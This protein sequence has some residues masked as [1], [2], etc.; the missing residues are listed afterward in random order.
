[1]KRL[2]ELA[3][4][5]APMLAAAAVLT[6]LIQAPLYLFPVLEGSAYQGINIQQYGSDE[7]YYLLR[8]ASIARG[9]SPSDPVLREGKDAGDHTFSYAEKLLIKPAAWLGLFDTVSIVTFVNSVNAVGVFVLILLIYA[10]AFQLG[11]DKRLALATAVFVIGGY[12]IV[13]NKSF[14][15]SDFNVYG[16]MMFPLM[17]SLFFFGYLYF[18]TLSLRTGKRLHIA[19][20]GALFGALFYLYYFAWSFSLAA[21]GLLAVWFLLKKEWGQAR[22]V[23]I[24]L[25]MG[26]ALGAYNVVR[27]FSYFG[28]PEGEQSS[29]FAW[30]LH[31]H[32]PVFSL[33]SVVTLVVL[34]YFSFKTKWSDTVFIPL[35]F[36]L[37]GAGIAALNEQVI[38]GVLVQYG[39]YYWYFIVPLSIIIAA[40]CLWSLLERQSYKTI[41]VFMLVGAAFI[42]TAVGQYRSYAAVLEAKRYEQ[43]FAPALEIL[44]S[45]ERPGVVLAADDRDASLVPIYASRYLFWY[46]QAMEGGAP[47]ARLKEALFTYT[48]LSKGGTGDIKAFLTAELGKRERSM[49]ADLF[50]T[51][52]GLGSGLDYLVYVDK[53]AAHDPMLLARRVQV[54]DALAV[55]YESFSKTPHGVEQVLR[56]QGVGYILWDRNRY[57]DWDFSFLSAELLQEEGGIALYRVL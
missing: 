48:Y 3:V 2:R 43:H 17:S 7:H 15:Y 32:Q 19:S 27:L 18:L 50:R 38:T 13:Y 53:L 29:Y 25:G 37:V 1:M 45:D 26:I 42:N 51:L 35:A 16:R 46:T 20:A 28:S 30:S 5:H 57:P 24:V 44:A 49:Y 36:S 33:I 34:V 47:V 54:L 23:L 12:S 22:H 40:Y 31:T 39:H 8:A 56:D 9:G 52:E 21:T 10:F 41:F 4:A 55:E 11:R 14:F 6:L